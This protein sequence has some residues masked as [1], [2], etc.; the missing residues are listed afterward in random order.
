MST[1][2]SSFRF[3]RLG[4]SSGIARVRRHL[5]REFAPDGRPRRGA[6]SAGQPLVG[7]FADIVAVEVLE[8]LQVE[9]GRRAADASEIEPAGRVPRG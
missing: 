6:T 8:L 7:R 1:F 3:L 5:L 9:A 4:F 2:D